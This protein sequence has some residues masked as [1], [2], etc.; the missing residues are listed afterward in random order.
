[1]SQHLWQN[2]SKTFSTKY[3]FV[4]EVFFLFLHVMRVQNMISNIRGE[5]SQKI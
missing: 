4:E 5:I 2:R 1:M 3:I